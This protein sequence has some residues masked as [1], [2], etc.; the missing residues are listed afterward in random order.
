MQCI[1]GALLILYAYVLMFISNVS[2]H[3]H[4]YNIIVDKCLV[5]CPGQDKRI[6]PLFHPRMSLKAT[7]GA[8][9]PETEVDCDQMAM[10]L[11]SVT[12]HS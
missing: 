7:E 2:F 10:G 1:S 6:A 12:S 3:L 8:F 11:P 9:T 4:V 5:W